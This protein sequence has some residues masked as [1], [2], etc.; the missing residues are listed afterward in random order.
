MKQTLKLEGILLGAAIVATAPLMAQN[1]TDTNSM[2]GM[3]STNSDQAADNSQV[4]KRD[5]NG[6]TRTPMDQGNS[7]EDIRLARQIRQA[8]VS[9]T[10]HFSILAQNIKIIARDG[11]VTLRGPVKT[12]E[13]RSAVAVIADGIAGTN[14]VKNLLE[15]KKY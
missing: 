13:E 1:N 5:Q 10:N 8:V 4:N 12:E 3:V 2:P 9:E 7:P 11:H 15:V 14:N 6:E